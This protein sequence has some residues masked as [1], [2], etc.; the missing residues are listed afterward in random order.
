MGMEMGMQRE[1]AAHAKSREAQPG[2]AATLDPERGHASG[3][4]VVARGT[5]VFAQ[6]LLRTRRLVLRPFTAADGPLVRRMAADPEVRAGA[7]EASRLLSDD[8]AEA[9][10]ATHPEQFAQG[11]LA[12]FA[13][14]RGDGS[15]AVGAAGLAV[16]ADGSAELGYWIAAE[17]RG[18]GYAAE[19]ARALVDFGFRHFDLH[20]IHAA[21]APRNRASGRVLRQAGLTPRRP[22]VRG[23]AE[24]EPLAHLGLARS[25][26][27]AMADAGPPRDRSPRS[28]ACISAGR[29]T[30][31]TSSGE[32]PMSSINRPLAGPMLTF[33]LARHVSELRADEAYR[34]SGRAG[35]TLAKAGRM[36]VT[37]VALADGASVGTHQADSPMTVHVLEGHIRFRVGG[38][39][40]E[41]SAGELLFF[42][43]C[44]A[45]DIRATDET[46]LLITLSAVGDDFTMERPD[47][48]E[49][50]GK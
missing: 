26:W 32:E 28:D 1:M 35:R 29:A 46:L 12:A 42:G 20:L 40:H 33:D 6:P 8:M 50:A 36:R 27:E 10:I 48:A 2:G 31:T 38:D 23:A 5:G 49:G 21:H 41:L 47:D 16:A 43:A 13:V 25:R 11:R 7:L 45:H 17:H 14:E 9:W 24:A 4:A 34:R 3:A 15:G 44:D 22:P 39:D 37:L 30:R 19:T 18:A